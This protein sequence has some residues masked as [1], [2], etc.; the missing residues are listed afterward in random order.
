MERVRTEVA[1]NDHELAAFF[2][3]MGFEPAARLYYS[4]GGDACRNHD[5]TKRAFHDVVSA[6]PLR[7]MSMRREAKTAAS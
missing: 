6:L 1:W 7:V 2:D 5:P 3:S 4:R